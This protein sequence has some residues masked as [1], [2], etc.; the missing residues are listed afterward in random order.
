MRAGSA[1]SCT[2]R[3]WANWAP[4]ELAASPTWGAAAPKPKRCKNWRAWAATV[5][6]A[7]ASALQAE[8]CASAWGDKLAGPESTLVNGAGAEEAPPPDIPAPRLMRNSRWAATPAF[9]SVAL[10]SAYKGFKSK[11]GNK[12][13]FNDD[14]K[15]IQIHAP[16]SILMTAGKTVSIRSGK[17]DD[18]SSIVMTEGKEIVMKTNGKSDSKILVDAGDGTVTIKAKKIIIDATEVIEMKAGKEIKADAK[19]KV[20]ISGGSKVEVKSM[21][22]KVDGSVKVEASGA[23]VNIKGSAMVDVKGALIKLN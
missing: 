3:S 14:E 10:S 22:V 12:W 11:G 13:K 7:G 19:S 4:A 6:P 21:E 15:S 20:A 5:R 9:S 8:R 17:K 16:T 2:G 23:Q 1:S 18:D